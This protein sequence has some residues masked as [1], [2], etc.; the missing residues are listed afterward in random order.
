MFEDPTG[1]L[2]IHSENYLKKTDFNN[3]VS[4]SWTGEMARS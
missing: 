1:K 4:L 2:S 3:K